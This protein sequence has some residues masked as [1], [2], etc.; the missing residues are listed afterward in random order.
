MSGRHLDVNIMSPS[1][2]IYCPLDFSVTI[3][4]IGS[5]FASKS[6]K[7][8]FT[9]TVFRHYFVYIAHSKTCH[10][11]LRY[12]IS[13]SNDWGSSNMTISWSLSKMQSQLM[14][15]RRQLE[16]WTLCIENNWGA[17]RSTGEYGKNEWNINCT[18]RSQ[19]IPSSII[20]RLST[21]HESTSLPIKADVSY[22]FVV[23]YKWPVMTIFRFLS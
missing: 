15:N 8:H 6:A 19:S 22:L 3:H 11:Q 10:A 14:S 18:T 21:F 23:H 5:I 13:Q 4:Q 1:R 12:D 20:C 7:D 17:Q 16:S 2:W 9:F